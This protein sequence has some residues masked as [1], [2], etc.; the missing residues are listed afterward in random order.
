MIRIE[1]TIFQIVK[2]LLFGC[3]GKFPNEVIGWKKNWSQKVN[4][5]VEVFSQQTQI[6][7]FADWRQQNFYQSLKRPIIY[8]FEMFS[9]FPVL[10]FEVSKGLELF[11]DGGV[12]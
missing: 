1:N 5:K 11:I 10:S 4:K 9:C 8:I 6:Y 12:T 3:V 2:R 7:K